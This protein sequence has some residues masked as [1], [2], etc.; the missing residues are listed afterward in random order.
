M[1]RQNILIY[2][3]FSPLL[4]SQ[5]NY[6]F[7]IIQLPNLQLP[8]DMNHDGTVI[9]GTD[10]SGQAI[11]WTED[12]GEQV[13]GA[14]EAWGVSED[15]RIFAEMINSNGNRE[16]AIIEN[17]EITFL[18]NVEG[19]GTCDAFL[20]HGL[21]ISA[22]GFTGVGMGWINCGTEAFYWT[23]DSGIVELG[24]YNGSS[25]K[26]QAISGDG[27]VI[28]GWAQTSNRASCLWDR[29]GN[30]TFLGSLQ[31]GNDYGEVMAISQD[32]TQV[33]GYCAGSGA[34]Q[35]EAYIW[36]E[37]T[38]M[39]GLG[40]PPNNAQFNRSQ[41]LSISE[42]N[43][44][45]GQYL[46]LGMTDY[47]ACIWTD[48]TGIM[49]DL[50][51]HLIDKG[52]DGLEDWTLM[53]GHC[54]SSDGS[55]FAGYG[56]VGT[57]WTGWII[58]MTST[59]LPGNILLV[60]SEYATVQDA[61]IASSDRDTVLIAPGTYEEQINF[62]GKKIV[63]GSYALVYGSAETFINQT[64]IDGSGSGSV[65]T[66]NSGEDSSAV[67]YG[68]TL[69]NGNAEYGG[70]IMIE[71]SEPT[72]EY[73]IIQNNNGQ[74]GG[75][76][77]ARYE[78]EPVF[79][80]VTVIN[81][82]A[83]QGGGLRFRDNANPH[84][85][86]CTI[87]WNTAT[88]EGGGIY[89]NNANPNVSYSLITGNY[90]MD[91][92]DA[93]YLKINCEAFF[94]Y[95]TI[96][97]NGSA[98]SNSS[99]GVYCITNCHPQFT[100]TIVWGNRESQIEFSE[101]SNSNMVTINYCD[102]EGGMEG[103][104]TNNNGSVSW[105]TGNIDENPLFCDSWNWDFNLAEDSPCVGTGIAGNNMGAFDVGC[106]P[107]MSAGV[108][109]PSRFN[110]KQNYPNP[111]NSVTTIEYYLYNKSF[112]NI[113]IYDIYGRRLKTLFNKIQN[114]GHWS[115]MWDG[116]D[117]NGITAPSGIYLYKLSS[118]DRTKTRKMFLLK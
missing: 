39:T 116:L 103:I 81:N 84:I 20:S 16:A 99:S 9:V 88:S 108:D 37:S 7:E 23:D 64:V 1:K 72:I 13:L 85:S 93:V 117:E 26:A 105:I 94:N 6:E 14:G 114:Q 38:G 113:S 92:G 17:G 11:M 49:I 47:R 58:R 46:Y 97:S 89:C 60:P 19:G 5:P 43:T 8:L 53:K 80:H 40:V 30:I 79:N 2:F 28:G 67:L 109:I 50:K 21:G 68:L 91:G 61:I 76:V 112:I 27:Q 59:I 86:N 57:Q 33:V 95:T 83:S 48:S 4:I 118:G 62:G 15:G 35:S 115:I 12:D 66:F 77:Y 24:Q 63:V 111:F 42:N 52:M 18:G 29:E 82:S 51:E 96:T 104:V 45:I 106:G 36:T 74:Y 71:S 55:V 31:G 34:N 44:V 10:F 25:T 22:D 101:A 41:A 98:E 65:A 56:R 32:G 54:V 69:Q 70:G 3:I 90:A 100:S 107:M 102:I 75:G 78:C 110:L 87:K 73:L